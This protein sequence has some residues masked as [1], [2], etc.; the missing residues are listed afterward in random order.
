MANQV[1]AMNAAGVYAECLKGETSPE[2]KRAIKKD[3]RCG[4][5]LIKL[6][7]VT[8]EMCEMDHFRET[9]RLLNKHRELRRIVIDEAHCVSEWGHDFRKSF[10]A[11]KF[12]REQFPKVPITCCTATAVEAVRDDVIKTLCLNP[13]RTK[14]F[15]TSSSRPNLHFE[16]IFKSHDRRYE[17]LKKWLLAIHK[18]RAEPAR[19]AQLLAAS[20]KPEHI[21]GVVYVRSRGNTEAI[22]KQL[23]SD[24]LP[25]K[26][27]HAGLTKEQRA[28]HL[29]GWV[30]NQPGYSIIVA[31]IAFG[32]G[33]DKED[34]RFVIHLDMPKSFE[35]YYQEAGRAG[36]DG[37][38]SACR[39][40]YDASEAHYYDHELDKKRQGLLHAIN[41]GR[42]VSASEARLQF[43]E[44]RRKSLHALVAYCEAVNG[45]RHQLIAKYFVDPAPVKCEWACDWHKDAN[46]LK[47]ENRSMDMMMLDE[48]DES[49][50]A[51][52]NPWGDGSGL[53]ALSCD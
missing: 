12:F 34:V 8:P 42:D 45:C 31:T 51:Y 27:Y 50:S 19:S 21:S 46:K 33:I 13:K 32:M 43:L 10:L 44:C 30:E 15:L 11:L 40:Y 22:A 48:F 6:L 29:R 35:G 37:K 16:V 5:P 23:T 38:A 17:D 3:L 2:Q 20:Q 49:P 4:H 25:S 14:L 24:G 47:K 36:R 53:V 39:M 1:D 52:P 26:P 41:K 28:D 18:R 7:Y 9:L